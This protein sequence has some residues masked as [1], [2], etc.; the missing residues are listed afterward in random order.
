M[1]NWPTILGIAAGIATIALLYILTMLGYYFLRKKFSTTKALVEI[2]IVA[3]ALL[4]SIVVKFCVF[5]T[6]ADGSFAD[7]FA[8]ALAAIY[9]A[10]AG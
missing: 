6:E 1:N 9:A 4:L 2:V 3:A 10:W 7:A 5:L 8:T